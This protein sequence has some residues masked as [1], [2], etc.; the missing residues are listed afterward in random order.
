[1]EV[2]RIVASLVKLTAPQLLSPWRRRYKFRY[3]A[4]HKFSSEISLTRNLLSKSYG[5][6]NLL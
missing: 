5:M 2:V 6:I 1:M 3:L 4:T